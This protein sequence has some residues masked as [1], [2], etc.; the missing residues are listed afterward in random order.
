MNKFIRLLLS[1]LSVLLFYSCSNNLKSSSL[2]ISFNLPN[3][4]NQNVQRTATNQ[5]N[6]NVTVTLY[7]VLTTENNLQNLADFKI[8]ETQTVPIV[9]NKA[10]VQIDDIRIGTNALITAQIT[11]NNQ[12][13][14]EGKSEFFTV[15][16]GENQVKIQ[17]K[18]V[19]SS[20][21]VQIPNSDLL[22]G[23]IDADNNTE[24]LLIN[25][26]AGLNYF[27]NIV[28]GTLT[29]NIIVSDNVVYRSGTAYPT[30]NAKLCNDITLTE[31]YW[32]PIG[33]STNYYQGTFD[34][35]GKCVTNLNI[36]TDRVTDLGFFGCVQD[37][38][39]KNLYVQGIISATNDSSQYA[40]GGIVGYAKSSEGKSVTISNCINNVQIDY[41]STY[42]GGILGNLSNQSEIKIE[43]CVNIAELTAQYPSGILNTYGNSTI[44][45]CLNLGNLTSTSTAYNRTAGI[46][47]TYNVNC[48][49]SN[50]INTGIINNSMDDTVSPILMWKNTVSG[51]SPN[52][53]DCFYDSDKIKNHS[54]TSFG[55]G[56]P[57]SE[58]DTLTLE[59][60]YDEGASK[61]PIPN[62]IYQTFKSSSCWDNILNAISIPTNE[63]PEPSTEYVEGAYFVNG[64]T[65]DDGNDG[66]SINTPYKKLTTAITKAIVSD[67]KTVYVS[68]TLEPSNQ[69]VTNP[70]STAGEQYSVFYIQDNTFTD[71]VKIIGVTENTNFSGNKETRIFSTKNACNF[72]MK[73]INFING[74]TEGSGAAIYFYKGKLELDNCKISDNFSSLN[75]AYNGIYTYGGSELIMTNTTCE[76]SVYLSATTATIGNDCVIGTSNTT[77]TNGFIT[78]DTSTLTLDGENIVI[79]KPIYVKNRSSSIQIGDTY[80]SVEKII[81]KLASVITKDYDNSNQYTLITNCDETKSNYFTIICEDS[82]KNAT[83]GADG[84]ITVN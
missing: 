48:S 64:E 28:N 54:E 65:G 4:K 51:S 49:V 76:N 69:D 57:S 55:S 15:F 53:T 17:L 42:V 72:T 21:N 36:T 34:G 3:Q 2:V 43:S 33:N 32:V 84:K 52:C 10:L 40:V 29:E 74:N 12:T 70:S 20:V 82:T 13:L 26:E 75:D 27:R 18:K 38:T 59:G 16:E 71:V 1:F 8:I 81:I 24:G 31:D 77:A 83:L 44:N 67:A 61:Y 11:Q 80:S 22:F 14:Y 30:V 39:I 6:I 50:C 7:D 47:M 78:L 5:E 41:Q 79:H 9:N 56:I 73:N 66:L 60:W 37:A 68:G 62:T 58:L 63:N 25:S 23:K 46:C 35:N 19:S 45:N